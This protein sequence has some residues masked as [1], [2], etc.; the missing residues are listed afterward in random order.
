MKR[1]SPRVTAHIRPAESRGQ[2][3]A[4]LFPWLSGPHG[5]AARHDVSANEEQDRKWAWLGVG[6]LATSALACAALYAWLI[7][8]L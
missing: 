8:V 7:S 5:G 3:E 6:I 4:L 1:H 2:P